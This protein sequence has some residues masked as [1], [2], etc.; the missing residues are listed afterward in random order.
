[1]SRELAF[2]IPIKAEGNYEGDYEAVK[3]HKE[4]TEKEKK[5]VEALIKVLQ[6]R[7]DLKGEEEL[8]TKIGKLF[9]T[10]EHIPGRNKKIEGYIESPDSPIESISSALG[11]MLGST[12]NAKRTAWIISAATNEN[13]KDSQFWSGSN[14]VKDINGSKCFQEEEN[15]I[16]EVRKKLAELQMK[17]LDFDVRKRKVEVTQSITCI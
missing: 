14:W 8:E 4:F 1:M 15:N 5:Q 2:E 6:Y 3:Y 16:Q 17:Y 11:S 12:K 13:E 7:S 10:Y 9:I